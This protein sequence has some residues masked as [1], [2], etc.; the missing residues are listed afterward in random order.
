MLERRSSER[1]ETEL[2]HEFNP[3]FGIELPAENP[4]PNAD[5]QK[6]I[7]TEV[8]VK[9]SE[10]MLGIEII[11]GTLV[12]PETATRFPIKDGIPNMLINEDQVA[13]QKKP[14]TN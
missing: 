14:A 6:D 9:I 12:C 13:S 10:A 5:V 2:I 11:E 4:A 3:Q 8:S 7:P 1:L